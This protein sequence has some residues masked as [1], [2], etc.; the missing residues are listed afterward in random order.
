MIDMLNLI[1]LVAG[2]A[3]GIAGIWIGYRIAKK[4]GAFRKVVLDV[5]LMSQS[6]IRNPQ[7]EE[8]I[9]GYSVNEVDKDD[10]VLCILP[11]KISNSGELSAENIA[12]RFVFPL[13]LRRGGFRDDLLEEMDILGAYDKSDIKRKSFIKE[14]FE[15]V[16]Y[17]LPRINPGE[18]AVIEEAIDITYASG[19]PFNVN[20]V[21]KDAVPIKVKGHVRWTTRTD[22][23]VSA[24]NVAPLVGHFCVRSYQFQDQKELGKKIRDD[25][26]RNLREELS[27]IGAPEGF[28][29]HVYAPFSKIVIVPKLE[30]IPKTKKY[31]AIKG[32]VYIGEVEKSEMWLFTNDEREIK[33][34]VYKPYKIKSLLK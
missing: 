28:I 22:L 23:R 17:L 31:S 10:I 19:I 25:E 14:G 12:V 7:F 11:F 29:Q 24:M 26:T 33:R 2:I 13:I 20:T 34:P 5:S 1:S 6:L 3:I 18:S 30:K 4:S 16:D 9:F 8:V 27:K 15:Y 32:F 21:T